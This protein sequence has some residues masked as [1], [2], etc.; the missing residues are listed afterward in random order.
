MHKCQLQTLKYI[1]F[2]Y[3]FCINGILRWIII[4]ASDSICTSE[5]GHL[6]YLGSMIYYCHSAQSWEQ[7]D[8]PLTWTSNMI[9]SF[10]YC[11]CVFSLLKNN[12]FSELWSF[13]AL[14]NLSF[15]GKNLFLRW[16]SNPI[17]SNRSCRC[18]I[19]NNIGSV[20]KMQ[21]IAKELYSRYR[22]FW[23]FAKVNILFFR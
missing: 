6:P 9:G 5:R 2:R 11:F 10:S 3:Y 1:N 12:F 4:N 14:F 21:W 13:V 7:I 23:S 20:G 22:K 16:Q 18:R 19:K 17:D 15:W 8:I